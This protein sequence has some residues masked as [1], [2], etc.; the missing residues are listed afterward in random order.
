MSG[1]G[2]RA[3][4]G[5]VGGV[6]GGDVDVVLPVGVHGACRVFSWAWR[7]GSGRGL[8]RGLDVSRGA[9]HHHVPVTGQNETSISD[10]RG[11]R[12]THSH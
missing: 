5:A 1:V 4:C 9:P 11:H 6:G 8:L 12:E 7:R 10:L 3:D 2:G